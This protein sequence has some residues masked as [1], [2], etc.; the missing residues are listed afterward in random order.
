MF[1]VEITNYESIEHT[2][3]CV[4]KFTT[5]T[6]K[7][8]LGKSAA[9]RAINAA[10][11]NQQ[12][13]NFIRWGE[14]FCEVHIKT[15]NYDIL[16]H[17]EDGNNFYNINGKVYNKIGRDAPPKEIA[18]AGFDQLKVGG[19]KINLNYSQQFFPLFLVDK[20]DSKGADLLTSVYGLDRLYKAVD[21]CNRDQ[22]T[23]KDTLRLRE[24]DLEFIEKD[25]EKFKSF[26]ILKEQSENLKKLKKSVDE[27]E[28]EIF[29]LRK[30]GER[31]QILAKAI[32]ILQK[33]TKIEIPKNENSQELAHEIGTLT[34]LY[35]RYVIT[36]KDVDRL[37]KIEDISIPKNEIDVN[38]LKY[39]KDK[40]D[41]ILEGKKNLQIIQEN[42]E[43]TN[44]EITRVEEEK[45]KYPVCP[46]CGSDLKHEHN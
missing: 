20:L 19:Q 21:L 26:E 27:K 28:A 38:S 45:K 46:L 9:L 32:S 2:T 1:E 33:V 14:T 44:E 24:K 30:W 10:L 22:R 37:K 8:A 4:D 13:T 3:I 18:D 39:L 6:G 16:W 11:T 36:K 29:K 15:G 35:N 12:G 25:L 31:A 43:K 7:N 5:L 42:I 40:R 23:N 41:A 17:K 34:K